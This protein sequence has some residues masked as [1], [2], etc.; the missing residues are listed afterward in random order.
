MQQLGRGDGSRHSRGSSIRRNLSIFELQGASGAIFDKDSN[1]SVRSA[2]SFRGFR[3]KN[4]SRNGSRKN[5]TTVA[6]APIVANS[7][8]GSTLFVSKSTD[9]KEHNLASSSDSIRRA[10]STA[11]LSKA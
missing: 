6:S 3:S 7:V 4:G 8:H 10:Q 5:S 1:G 2:G 11:L 9:E